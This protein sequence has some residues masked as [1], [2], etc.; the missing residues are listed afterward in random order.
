MTCRFEGV[1]PAVHVEK[2]AGAVAELGQ[3]VKPLIDDYITAL[4][5]RKLKEGIRIAMAIS[6]VG[7]L[8]LAYFA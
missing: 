7:E 1:V 5:G 3:Q 6:S 2:G 8:T 4:E